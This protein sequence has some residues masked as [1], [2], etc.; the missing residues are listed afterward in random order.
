MEHFP[1]IDPYVQLAFGVFLLSLTASY[2][3]WC[4]FRVMIIRQDLFEI[5]GDLWEAAFELDCLKDDAYQ[6]ARVSLNAMIRSAHNMSLPVLLFAVLKFDDRKLDDIPKSSN[7]D[8]QKAIED[9]A[10]LSSEA[11]LRYVINC[12]P[13]S[14]WLLVRA[15]VGAASIKESVSRWFQ[16][17]GPSSFEPS[18]C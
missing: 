10:R 1:M 13:L 18:P 9:A 7:P 2:V 12:R 11:L 4:R 8:M 5:R 17:G 6:Q 14:G 15:A 3:V 16:G